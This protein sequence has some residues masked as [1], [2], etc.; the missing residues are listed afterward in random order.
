[1]KKALI[2]VILSLISLYI[3]TMAQTQEDENRISI[4]AIVADTQIPQEAAQ[5]LEIRMKQALTRNGLSDNGHSQRF[6]LA[7]VASI[8]QKDVVPTTPPR[9]SQKMELTFLLGDIIENKLID[10]YSISL[11]GIGITETK[12]FITAFQRFTPSDSGLQEM[13][14]NAKVKIVDYYSGSC[15]AIIDNANALAGTGRFDEA[16]FRL[17]SVPDVCRDC[18]KR[19]QETAI[20]IYK[21][22]LT[23]EAA[24][25]LEQAKNVWAVSPN[26][27]GAA[28][29]AKLISQINPS[30]SNYE[31][32]TAFRNQVAE[33]MKRDEKRDW[34]YEMKR[35]DNNQAFKMSLI[36]ACKAVGV[37][38]GNGQPE[39]VTK[40]IIRGWL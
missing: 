28:E 27:T 12:S 17:M 20:S 4:N 3:P 2:I 36:D 16:I 7:A 22:K 8:T 34:E 11:N 1:M 37:A 23:S 15:E 5:T 13:L 14:T 39:S 10:S 21:D 35:Y 30:S 29:V 31:S 32:V 38:F 19:C 40:N 18:Y 25:L 9:V 24:N 33:K 26:S 6:V